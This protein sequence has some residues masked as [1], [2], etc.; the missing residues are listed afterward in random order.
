MSTDIV[1]KLSEDRSAR[2]N[3]IH[4]SG[5]LNQGCVLGSNFELLLRARR[6]K[7]VLQQ[8]LPT[9]DSC[10]APKSFVSITVG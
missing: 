3:R 4:T 2:N 5:F 7:L 1:A 9:P 10:S 8:Y 6:P